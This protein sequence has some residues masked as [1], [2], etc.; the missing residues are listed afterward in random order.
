M[1]LLFLAMSLECPILASEMEGD[2]STHPTN[3]SEK[4]PGTQNDAFKISVKVNLVTTDVMVSGRG[5]TELRADDFLIYDNGVLQEVAAFSYDQLPIDIVLLV[6]EGY[7]RT[8]EPIVNTDPSFV[9]LANTFND[10]R[11][12]LFSMVQISSLLFLENLKPQDRVALFSFGDYYD[13]HSELSTDRLLIARGINKITEEPSLAEH[14]IINDAL[15]VAAHYL[16]EK[17]GNRRRAI[18][19]I[20]DNLGR[21]YDSD[22]KNILD[23]MLRASTTLYSIRTLLD[24][25][26][27]TW[28]VAR[29]EVARN[30]ARVKEIADKSG[31]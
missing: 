27:Q 6:D 26:H 18:I 28:S 15:F 20:A 30:S 24:E 13:V 14:R 19:L 5:N 31:G 9:T 3:H 8:R 21:I 7:Y 10:V 17:G 25:V 2:G 4:N 23:E 12:D 22:V 16:H 29:E 1:L 11:R